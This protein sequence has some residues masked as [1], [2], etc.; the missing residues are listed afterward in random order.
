MTVV[1][2]Q[3]VGDQAMLPR[4]ELE[5]L[6]ELARRS[7]A[8]ELVTEQE[9]VPAAGIRW[10]AEQAALDTQRD[11]L[12]PGMVLQ[13]NPPQGLQPNVFSQRNTPASPELTTAFC[14]TSPGLV[15]NKIC[16]HKATIDQP[17]PPAPSPAGGRGGVPL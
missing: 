8:V 16:A 13:S 5:K 4:S 15:A 2:A 3:F 1:H 6:L 11:I 9:E 7:E 17:R 12:L 14:A 10:L